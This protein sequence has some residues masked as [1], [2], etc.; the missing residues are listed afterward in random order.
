MKKGDPRNK[1]LQRWA[2]WRQQVSIEEIATR[3][4][5][6]IEEIQHSI[7]HV[8]EFQQ[9]HSHEVVDMRINKAVLNTLNGVDGGPLEKILLNLAEA[10][11]VLVGYGPN[12]EDPI[13]EPDHDSRI[14]MIDTLMKMIDKIRPRGTGVNV[15]VAQTNNTLNVSGGATRSFEQRIR[16]AHEKHELRAAPVDVDNGDGDDDDLD[17]DDDIADA[18]FEDSDDEA[19]ADLDPVTAEENIES[20]T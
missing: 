2:L 15:N 17:D 3:W 9:L 10:K 11:K 13:L 5:T 18:E 16:L 14:K 8:Q 1:D 7:N 6:S 19:V 12:G 20:T 4:N